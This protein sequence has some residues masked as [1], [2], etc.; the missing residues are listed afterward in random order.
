MNRTYLKYK[1]EDLSLKKKSN[2]T[3]LFD[4]LVNFLNFLIKAKSLK[5]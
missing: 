2:S 3:T 5:S 4:F 1:R